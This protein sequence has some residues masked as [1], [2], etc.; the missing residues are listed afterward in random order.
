MSN[1]HAIASHEAWLAARKALLLKEKAFTKARDDLSRQRREL[2]WETVDKT[3]AFEG[4]DG[5]KT[6]AELFDGRHQLIVYHFMFLPEWD[7]G[8]PSCSFWADNFDRVIVHMNH[9]DTSMVAISH[10]AYPKLAAYR[11]RM[12]WGFTWLSSAGSDFN[13]D[14]HVAFTE[15]EMARGKALYNY[16]VQDPHI[17][18]REGVSVFYKADAG[19]IYHTYS[20]FARGIDLL[21][22]AYNYLDLTPKGR[23]EDAEEFPQFWVERHDEYDR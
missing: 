12:G 15:D 11:K 22:T 18:E 1:G 10:A 23:D 14:Y 6:L 4:A 16:T 9:R 8:C 20:A 2:P 3:Y 17:A 5:K 7:E 19:T 13:Y 21:N